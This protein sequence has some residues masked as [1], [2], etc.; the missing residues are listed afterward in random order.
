L[1]YLN[2]LYNQVQVVSYRSCLVHSEN[3]KLF[4]IPRHIN[5]EHMNEALDINENKN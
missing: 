5:L 2:M 3:Q 1:F 4:K